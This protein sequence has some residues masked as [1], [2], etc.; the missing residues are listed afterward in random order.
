MLAAA[1][2]LRRSTDFAAAVR[3]GRRAGRGAVVVHLTMPVSADPSTPTSSQPVRDNSAEQPSAP[4]RAGFVVS[5]A[6][7]N[8]VTRNKVQRR[9]RELVRERLAALPEGSTL[10]VR[11]LPAAAEAS[12]PRLAT[13][14]DAALAVARSSRERRSR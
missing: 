10:V 13:D 8:A 5:K 14:L 6:V 4:S 3:G 12:Y 7:G 2:R 9:L 1:Q 11:A